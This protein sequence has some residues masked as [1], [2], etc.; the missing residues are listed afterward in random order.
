VNYNFAVDMTLV[1]R[2]YGMVDFFFCTRSFLLMES[3]RT[4]K[5]PDSL[6]L[7]L[8]NKLILILDFPFQSRWIDLSME[9]LHSLPACLISLHLFASCFLRTCYH[10]DV[11]LDQI[12][13]IRPVRIFSAGLWYATYVLYYL[14]WN[15]GVTDRLDSSFNCK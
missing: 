12:S 10:H 4:V 2:A 1:R 8:L 15:S 11:F 13:R 7:S 14:P 6:K 5:R 9:K 3:S